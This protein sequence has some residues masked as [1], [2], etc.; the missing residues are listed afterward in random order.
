MP[1]ISNFIKRGVQISRTMQN[2][3]LR[4]ILYQRRVLRKLLRKASFTAF[5][6]HY[7]F[8]EILKSDNAIAQ[9]Q[10][11]VP[12]FDYDSIHAQWWH[13]TLN[14]EADVCWPGKIKYFALSSG[15]SGAPSKHIPITPEI[16]R[17][18][19]RS[20]LR[21]LSTLANHRTSPTLFGKGIM[22]LGGSTNLE[23]KGGYYIGDLSGIN[24]AQIPFWF[25]PF[26]KPGAGIAAEKDWE[27][28]ITKIA[29]NAHNW[30]IGI[31]GG[32]P[33]WIQLLMERII[34]YHGVETIHDVWP[35]LEVFISGGITFDPYEKSFQKLTKRPLTV[36]D[37]Y[38]ASEG[39]IAIQTRPN[40]KGMK[41]LLNNNIFFEF[42]PFNEQNFDENGK[43]IGKPKVLTI[44]DVKEGVNYALLMS[45]NAG[46]WRYQI[47]DTIRFIDKSK[48][49]IIITGR[50]Q[51]FLSICGEHLSVMNM[52]DAV[53]QVS[54][55]LNINILEFTVSGVEHHNFFAHKWYIGCDEPVDKTI[56]RDKLDTA[57]K[58]LNADYETERTA[59]LKD[60][61]IE[62]I[63]TSIFYQWHKKHGKMGG[64]NK[65]PR[66]MKKAKF[67]VWENF[68]KEIS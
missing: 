8:R 38:L 3:N 30:D 55:D 4:P 40:T 60:V 14:E 65:F 31:I 49:E 63:P 34:E 48:S 68:V 64:Q 33:S 11:N 51:H 15:T 61:I 13:R 25:R 18:I 9:F 39:Y 21:L 50:T 62:I 52:T 24:A 66:V 23:P 47:G 27:S 42:I 45:T 41:I 37:T 22:L 54:K 19:R 6:K 58:V 57:L 5:G 36:V 16:L 17:S 2:R 1:I 53:N 12:I 43:L 7:D 59:V 26:Y 46:V 44:A 28:R 32:I 29:Q 10:Q 56:F 35:N 20:S 67:E